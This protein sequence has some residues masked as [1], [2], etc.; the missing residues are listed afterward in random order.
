MYLILTY[1]YSLKMHI[2]PLCREENMENTIYKTIGSWNAL[3]YELATFLRSNNKW[4]VK[5]YLNIR[6]LFVRVYDRRMLAYTPY[7]G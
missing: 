5:P 6:A 2:I 3:R 7:A 4:T 1:K